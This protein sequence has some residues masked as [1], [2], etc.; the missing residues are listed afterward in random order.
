MGSIGVLMGGNSSERPISLISGKAV[1]EALRNKGCN[2][3]D[4]VLE[5]CE[6]DTLI[7]EIE[8][9][10]IDI[11]FIAL[12]GKG[13]ED[14]QIQKYLRELNILFS[15]S[16]PEASSLAFNKLRAK[17][18][19]EKEGIPTPAY[20]VLGT[21]D[22][23]AGFSFDFPFFAKPLEE[24]SS[25]GVLR[26][27]N[28]DELKIKMPGL[29]GKYQKLLIEKA[30]LGREVTVGI[31][32]DKVLPL[33]ELIPSHLFYDYEAKYTKGLTKYIFPKDLTKEKIALISELALKAHKSLKLSD[34]SRVDI[35]LDE[36]ENPF[37]LEVNTIPGFT[38][39]SLLP[40]AAQVEGYDLGDVCLKILESA[41]NRYF[42]K[43]C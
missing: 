37:V 42:Q 5:N 27:E 24:G 7:K 1:S 15:G 2:V 19:F 11:V 14:G 43:S 25:V 17:R 4:I 3:V 22:T 18:V 26:I 21:T 33:I 40:K 8:A 10:D 30:I 29:L 31:L 36:M 16:D 20:S 38:D 6:K 41:K 28:E 9:V 34:F 39:V 32:E 12:H 23:L 35:M 13:G